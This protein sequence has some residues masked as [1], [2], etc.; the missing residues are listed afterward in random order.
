MVLKD[1]SSSF[2]G[3]RGNA[4]LTLWSPA[5]H[6]V[7]K[8]AVSETLW[9]LPCRGSVVQFC[10]KAAEA[11]SVAGSSGARPSVRSY[12]LVR[13]RNTHDQPESLTDCLQMAVTVMSLGWSS[14][15]SLLALGQADGRV[16]I[17]NAA[18]VALHLLDAMLG[19]PVSSLAWAP[20][21]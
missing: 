9:T 20:C 3:V 17:R 2:F 14:D 21:R 6:S 12:T 16:A 8:D 4:S 1:A 13:W 11:A 5:S 18:G 19:V 10:R 7:L 15:G